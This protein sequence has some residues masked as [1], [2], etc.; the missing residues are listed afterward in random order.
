MYIKSFKKIEVDF[1]LL[2]V[3]SILVSVTLEIFVHSL[4]FQLLFK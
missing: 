2:F 3:F 1:E 4:E